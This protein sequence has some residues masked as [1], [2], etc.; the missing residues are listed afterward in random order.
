MDQK[1]VLIFQQVD[2]DRI[3][4]RG[5]WNR[6]D[7]G[8]RRRPASDSRALGDDRAAHWARPAQ[9]ASLAVADGFV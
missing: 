8:A 9:T 3:L 7:S 1:I 5:V 4:H 6:T 2:V